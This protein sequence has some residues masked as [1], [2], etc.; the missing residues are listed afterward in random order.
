MS[1]SSAA[2]RYTQLGWSVIPVDGTTK[3][4]LIG[5]W[6]EFQTRHPTSEE[7][8]SWSRHFPKG[9][10]AVIGGPVSGLLIL[11]ADG[12]DGVAEVRRRGLPKTPTATTPGGGMHI[13]FQ[14]PKGLDGY[15]NTCKIGDSRKLD[16]RG[17]PGSNQTYVVAP[18]SKRSDG[19]RYEW[20]EKPTVKLAQI[21]GWLLEMLR[22][23]IEGGRQAVVQKKGTTSRERCRR[24][25]RLPLGGGP[26][27]R[28][29]PVVREWIETGHDLSKFQS[30][31]ECDFAVV[32]ALL[33]AGASEEE[34]EDI[35][36]N[37]P[38]GARY[39][40]EPNAEGQ[41]RGGGQRY[42]AL[43]LNEVKKKLRTVVVKYADLIDYGG[44]RRLQLALAPEEGSGFIRT[45]VTVPD[46]GREEL[47]PRWQKVFEAGGLRPLMP[48]EV[49]QHAVERLVGRRMLIEIDRS[50]QQ[51][52]VVAFY[53]VVG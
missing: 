21:P 45:G 31:S 12:A 23:L 32:M 17:T 41:I 14:L 19:K 22:R 46:G 39:R 43:T 26:G 52:P 16:V 36:T 48:S 30:R 27:A 20:V 1:S 8:D 11:D 18:H 25:T 4:P 29:D 9:G 3:K 42:L 53:G 24:T 34:I 40:E 38:I 35:F 15:K 49:T 44:S 47:L 5:K 37:Y 50:R 7:I 10:I 6:K 13:Y 51:N 33:I 28:L 2:T